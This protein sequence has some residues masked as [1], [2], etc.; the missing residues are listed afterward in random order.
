MKA[1]PQY[2]NIPFNAENQ[3]FIAINYLLL[4]K[5]PNLAHF[6]KTGQNINAAVH[7]IAMEWASFA[8]PAGMSRDKGLGRSNGQQS[9][10]S[11]GNKANME[12]TAKV[13]T[14]MRAIESYY[15]KG[16]KA[17]AASTTTKK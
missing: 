2:R 10:Y 8:V 17:S 12:A 11:S 9:Y 15:Q 13:W 14:V 4:T 3:R 16:G 7:D 5:R 1:F 6:L